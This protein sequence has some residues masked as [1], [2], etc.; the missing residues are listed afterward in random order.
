MGVTVRIEGYGDYDTERERGKTHLV[1]VVV[2]ANELL[3]LGLDV[4]DLLGRELELHDRNARL[5][6]VLQEPDLRRLQEHQTATLAVCA[7]GGTTDSV[8]VVSRVIWG[9]ELDDPVYGGNL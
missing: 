6:Q 9:I 1:Q 5:L 8:D 2:L 7:T 3:Q 4:D